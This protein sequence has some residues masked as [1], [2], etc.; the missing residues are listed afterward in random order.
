MG[1]QYIM[2]MTRTTHFTITVYADSPEEARKLAEDGEYEDVEAWET[3]EE[4]GQFYIDEVV[5]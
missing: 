2:D 4:V 3:D 5:S 1:K